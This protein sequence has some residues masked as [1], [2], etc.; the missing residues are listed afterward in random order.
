TLRHEDT[1]GDDPGVRSDAIPSF[2]LPPPVAV[3]PGRARVR[4]ARIGLP[5]I[6]LLLVAC[7]FQGRSAEPP[8]PVASPT[9]APRP[10]AEPA[11]AVNGWYQAAQ[12]EEPVRVWAD[13]TAQEVDAI[14]KALG[15]RYPRLGIQWRRASD[16]QLYQQ[17]LVDARAG[18]SGWDVYVGDSG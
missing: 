5:A 12:S 8:T 13:V 14:T 11:T 1:V 9:P 17:A 4:I 6:W 15:T 3:S 18:T 16:T 7:G 10:A 2:D